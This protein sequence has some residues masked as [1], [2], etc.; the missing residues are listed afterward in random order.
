MQKGEEAKLKL[1]ADALKGLESLSDFKY[2]KMSSQDVLAQ[3]NTD[4][5]QGLTS[6]EAQK[7]QD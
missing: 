4:M 2:H 1:T 3:M 7:R 5:E 6:S